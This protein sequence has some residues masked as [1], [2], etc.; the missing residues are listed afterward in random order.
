MMMLLDVVVSGCGSPCPLSPEQLEQQQQQQQQQSHQHQQQQQQQQQQD[1]EMNVVR[2][3]LGG[4]WKCFS[5][6]NEGINVVVC[7]QQGT[8][9]NNHNNKLSILK[10]NKT[11]THQSTTTTTTIIIIIIII[12][13]ITTTITTGKTEILF[14]K[15]QNHP[16]EPIFWSNKEIWAIVQVF[17]YFILK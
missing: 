12:I 15:Q 17:D 11:Y 9:L 3:E 13:T 8:G 6:E 2:E 5:F 16:G 10:Q 14:S 7:R 1:F 4:G